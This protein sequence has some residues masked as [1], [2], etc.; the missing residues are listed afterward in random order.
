DRGLKLFNDAAAKVRKAGGDTLGGEDAFKLHDTFGVYIDIT[1]Q[2]AAEAG[3]KVDR[4]GY[5][6]LMEE[7][8]RK[9]REAQKKHVVTAVTGDLPITDDAAKYASG[10]ICATVLGWVAGNAVVRDGELAEGEP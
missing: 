2:M 3:L 10:E 7:A 8:K 4:D 5:A 9:A 6:R 1:E